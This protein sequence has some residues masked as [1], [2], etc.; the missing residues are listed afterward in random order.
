MSPSTSQG[1]HLGQ[2]YVSLEVASCDGSS[3]IEEKG[4]DMVG[5]WDVLLGLNNFE[6]NYVASSDSFVAVI[7]MFWL[8]KQLLGTPYMGCARYIQFYILYIEWAYQY[9]I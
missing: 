3:D 1:D 6:F 4:H 5:Q 7:V 9:N 2:D 8:Q